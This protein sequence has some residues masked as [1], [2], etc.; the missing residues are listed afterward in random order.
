MPFI[1]TVR[2]RLKD[3]DPRAA[4]A[5]HNR[6]VASLIDVTQANGGV[7][8]RAYANAEDPRDFLGLDTWESMEGMQ[9]AFG[10]IKTQ[11][12]IGG[13]FDGPPEIKVWSLRD[14]WTTF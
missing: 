13:L 10:D 11:T 8:H 12:A 9:K 4:L 6:V 3:A 14:G 2:A 7:G 1:T 5:A